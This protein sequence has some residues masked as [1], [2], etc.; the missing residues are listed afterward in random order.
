MRY[1]NISGT[2]FT[3]DV[4]GKQ[5]LITAQHVIKGISTAA[6]IHIYQ[7]GW[8]PFDVT[9]VGK[10]GDDNDL[11]EIGN[12]GE[13]IDIAVL[14]LEHPLFQQTFPLEPTPTGV[15]YGQDAYFLGFPSYLN[16]KLRMDNGFPIPFVR[17]AVI[18]YMVP[19]D[20]ELGLKRF[21]LDGHNNPGFSGGPVIFRDVN[22]PLDFEYRVAAVISGFVRSDEP[23]YEEFDGKQR[24]VHKTSWQYN[25]GIVV[26]ECI[27]FAVEKIKSNPI[28]CKVD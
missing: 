6:R 15:C 24:T 3:I 14:A 12:F 1:Q 16:Y 4:D 27:N 18:S 21:Y 25:T 22:N 17:K 19:N 13:S 10:C 5:Y 20:N 9:L 23:V 2:C 28:G 26:A 11:T 8:K 7:D